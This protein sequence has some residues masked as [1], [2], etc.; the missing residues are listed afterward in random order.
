V[1]MDRHG[2]G[3]SPVAVKNV[4]SISFFGWREHCHKES[5]GIVARVQSAH[6]WIKSGDR[7][8]LLILVAFP[9]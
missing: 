5:P 3:E 7:K 2:I 8:F 4:T 6:N 9:G 1:I